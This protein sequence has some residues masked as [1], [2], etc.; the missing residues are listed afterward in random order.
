MNDDDGGASELLKR[1][2]NDADLF[3]SSFPACCFLHVR[4]IRISAMNSN[5]TWPPHGPPHIPPCVVAHAATMLDNFKSLSH[6]DHHHSHLI[7][8]SASARADQ[9]TRVQSFGQRQPVTTK[10]HSLQQFKTIYKALN[11]MAYKALRH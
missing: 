5:L 2:P 8:I 7:F 3:C 10:P 1:N 4:V 6:C 9:L 11:H